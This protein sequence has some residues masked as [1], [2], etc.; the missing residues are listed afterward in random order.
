MPLRG[1]I[2]YRD[3]L[4]VGAVAFLA[5]AGPGLLLALGTDLAVVVLAAMSG[6]GLLVLAVMVVDQGR[7]L[8]AETRRAAAAARDADTGASDGADQRV[9]DINRAARSQSR[10]VR[11]ALDEH[12]E[13]MFRYLAAIQTRLEL[14]L[15]PRGDH[16]S[17]GDPATRGKE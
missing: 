13:R 17:P 12:E 3:A 14:R 4:G 2:G 10:R 15:P 16:P 5:V 7:R 11:R 9:E 1:R 8:R 6:G